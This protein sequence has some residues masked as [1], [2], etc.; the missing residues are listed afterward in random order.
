M[1]YSN[2]R[3]IRV[4][5]RDT[6][7]WKVMDWR[8]R[9]VLML[10]LRK[11]TRSGVLDVGG[12]GARGLAAMIEMPLEVVGEGL[13]QLIEEGVVAETPTSF[14]LPKFIEAQEATTSD[15][16][17]SRDYRERQRDR[18]L[19]GTSATFSKP[20]WIY[21]CRA[22]SGA[23]KIGHAEDVE[24][25]L[26]NLRTARPDGLELL[27]KWPGTTGDEKALLERFAHLRVSGE[28][29]SDDGSIAK[30]VS[31]LVTGRDATETP[32]DD[33][34]TGRHA[35]SLDVTL[36]SRVEENREDPEVP[37]SSGTD[38]GVDIPPE[39]WT[40]AD[41]LR[42]LVLGEQPTN[43]IGKAP[44]GPDQRK[45]RRKAWA[46]EFRL[47]LTRDKRTTQ[48]L[49]DVLR[50]LFRGQTGDARFVVHSPSTL[51]EKWDRIVTQMGRGRGPAP[52]R[53]ASRSD[54]DYSRIPGMDAP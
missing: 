7:T 39:A 37:E 41:T 49:G 36:D 43:A 17:R 42:S 40:A 48:D 53:I 51:R 27:G 6:T 46:N 22:G 30:M 5:T 4:Y 28:W 23:I 50:F 31:S 45:G 54:D 10:L 16:Q 14:V 12:R 21:V 1:D 34:V 38:V 35:A 24:S 20:G 15:A 33:N 9:S 32:R 18:E 8:A 13:K 25:R 47:L 26:R 2:E 19:A 52:V 11:V 3:W 44:W 29:F